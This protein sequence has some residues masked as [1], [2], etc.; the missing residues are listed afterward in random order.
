MRLVK[1]HIDNDGS[2]T[3]TLC[4]EEPEDMVRNMNPVNTP[5]ESC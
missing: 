1:R 3:V 5:S 2:G 4:P